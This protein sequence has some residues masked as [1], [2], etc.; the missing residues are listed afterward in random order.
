[1]C[2]TTVT[3]LQPDVQN[4]H[5]HRFTMQLHGLCLTSTDNLA[6]L[7]LQHYKTSLVTSQ[8]QHCIQVCNAKAQFLGLFSIITVHYTDTSFTSLYSTHHMQ[9]ANDQTHGCSVYKNAVRQMCI[10]HLWVRCL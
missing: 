7:L 4:Q 6:S 10:L 2:L 1:M 9:F 8:M 5:Y 3:L